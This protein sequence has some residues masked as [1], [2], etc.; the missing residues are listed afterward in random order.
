MTSQ[1]I[2]LLKFKIAALMM[3]RIP[4]DKSLLLQTI[5]E[6]CKGLNGMSDD[7]IATYARDLEISL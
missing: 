5:M 2:S 4:K 6:G 7:E 3:E 1:E